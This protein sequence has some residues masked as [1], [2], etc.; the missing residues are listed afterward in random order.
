MKKGNDKLAYYLPITTSLCLLIGVCFDNI[1]AGACLGVGAAGILSLFPIKKNNPPCGGFF[2][3]SI[4]ITRLSRRG[5]ASGALPSAN[6][7]ITFPM[8]S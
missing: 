8:P 4:V 6:P 2:H 5:A 1:G 3:Y 7:I